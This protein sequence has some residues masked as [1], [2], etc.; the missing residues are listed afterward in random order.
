LVASATTG[1]QTVSWYGGV[2]GYSVTYTAGGGAALPDPVTAITWPNGLSPGDAVTLTL[3]T[4]LASGESLDITAQGTNPATPGTVN[5]FSVALGKGAPQTTT[6][7]VTYGTSVRAVSVAASPP[8]AGEA[9]TYTVSFEATG[10]GPASEIMLS[11]PGTDFSHVTGIFVTDATEGWHLL[12]AGAPARGS[13][14]LAIS[15]PNDL[16][17]PDDVVTVT[18][19]NVVNP[20]EGTVGDF[21]VSTNADIVA[22]DAP[23]Y[24]ISANAGA[25]TAVTVSVNPPLA[26]EEATYTI[27]NLQA[28]A[29]LVGG[30]SQITLN[31]PAGTVFPDNASFYTVQDSTDAASGG[32]VLPGLSGGGTDAVTITVRNNISAGDTL[33]VIIQ[34][35]LNPSVPAT[36]AMFISGDV[37]G[38]SAPAFPGANVSGP[39]GAIVDFSGTLFVFAGGHAFGMATPAQA[40]GV[41]ALDH[42]GVVIAPTGAVPPTTKPAPGTLL[43]VYSGPTIYV[44][45]ADGQ[46]H[47][48][49]T[50]AQFLTDGFDPADVITVPNLASMTVGLTAGAEGPAANALATASNGAIVDSSGAFFVLAGGRAFGIASPSALKA[51]EGAD[52]ALPVAGAVGASLVNALVADGTLLTAKGVVYT[53]YGDNL[54]PFKSMSQLIDDGYGGTPAVVVP[55][56][57]GLVVEAAYSGS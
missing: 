37:T 52:R 25:G 35:A 54:Y 45:G 57:G 30:V 49:A 15:A 13:A 12:V 50:P 31:G 2:A 38:A 41:E 40:A 27:S 26:G 7:E 6:N 11:E 36:D 18:L 24:V 32:T 28:S 39:D 34:D 17:I 10:A 1:T 9:A 33:S 51:V 23:A 19:A 55:S 44:V 29:I 4:P 56:T 48:F 46:L 47:G 8:V 20:P 43:V 5:D 3:A 22:V 53:S 16:I 21:S 14:R 42:A